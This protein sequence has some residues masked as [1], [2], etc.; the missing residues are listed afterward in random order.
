MYSQAL[1]QDVPRLVLPQ[2]LAS[3]QSLELVWTKGPAKAPLVHGDS[4]SGEKDLC[5]LCDALPELFPQLKKLHLTL[6]FSV[7]AIRSLG[8][9]GEPPN[10]SAIDTERALLGP[11]E[12]MLA[13]FPHESQT[14][15]E[16]SITIDQSFWS[17]LLRK[18]DAMRM[19]GLRA[20]TDLYI[21]FGRF[22]KRLP[23]QQNGGDGDAGYWLCSGQV[24]AMRG[25]GSPG[26][27]ERWGPWGD[28]DPGDDQLLCPHVRDETDCIDEWL[29]NR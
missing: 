27:Y 23:G 25:L 13:W 28:Y 4:D 19:P 15:G 10:Y 26:P 3:I 18:H 17:V 12:A 6:C 14:G 24:G 5:W 11:V 7:S 29:H 20:E 21:H 9:D 2:R 8:P 16:L 1:V 22:W